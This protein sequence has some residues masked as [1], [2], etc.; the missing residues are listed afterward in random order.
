MISNRFDP[1]MLIMLAQHVATIDDFLTNNLRINRLNRFCGCDLLDQKILNDL[2]CTWISLIQDY[3]NLVGIIS[4]HSRGLQFHW[5]QINK[6]IHY[7]ETSFSSIYC[8][9]QHWQVPNC[10]GVDI[11]N[12]DRCQVQ[13][14]FS[15]EGRSSYNKWLMSDH[16]MLDQDTNNYTCIGSEVSISL[17]MPLYSAPPNNYVSYCKETNLPVIGSTLNLGN[18]AKFDS[19]LV[20]LRHVYVRNVTCENNTASFR[21]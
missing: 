6:K 12:F 20:D 4:H 1:S 16:N 19:N 8:A 17:A 13:I 18:F 3:P 9:Q 10:F 5:D 2:H 21:I 14:M 15:Q 7:I 11:L